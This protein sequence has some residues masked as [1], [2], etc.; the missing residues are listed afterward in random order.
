MEK[1]IAEFFDDMV[2]EHI[3]SRM[4]P[5]INMPKLRDNFID[6]LVKVLQE[7]DDF[8]LGNPDLDR[9][10]YTEELTDLIEDNDV[11]FWFNTYDGYCELFFEAEN[12]ITEFAQIMYEKYSDHNQ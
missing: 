7:Y 2:K 8:H 4:L 5:Y 9:D 1:D 3:S 10:E 11:P 6:R 12:K